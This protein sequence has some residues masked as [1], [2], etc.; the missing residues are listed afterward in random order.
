MKKRIFF[1]LV[2]ALSA[3]SV[4]AQSEAE[5]DSIYS[6]FQIEEVEITARAL[7]KD[8]IVP[9]T[10]KGEVLQLMAQYQHHLEQ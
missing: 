1:I 7:N 8:I 4:F 3:G 9:Q 5:F 10:L 2:F 6:R